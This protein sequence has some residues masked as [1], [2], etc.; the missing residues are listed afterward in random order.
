VSRSD[1]S[2]TGF[3]VAVLRLLSFSSIDR[4]GNTDPLTN[5]AART[6]SK[7][8]R[9]LSRHF[10]SPR[11]WASRANSAD[12]NNL[13]RSRLS[14]L[15]SRSITLRTLKMNTRRDRKGT[16]SFRTFLWAHIKV[17]PFRKEGT[18]RIVY[19]SEGR[20]NEKLATRN[21]D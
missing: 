19:F 10:K 11:A 6:E 15:H 9:A 16:A 20:P 18:I 2:P 7:L 17:S 12:G 14:G 13:L 5:P 8:S 4:A 21:M 1:L 3:I